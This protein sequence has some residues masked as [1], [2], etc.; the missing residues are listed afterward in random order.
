M[1]ERTLG[2]VMFRAVDR[3]QQESVVSLRFERPQ[4]EGVRERARRE[5]FACPGCEAVVLFKAGE[6]RRPHFAHKSRSECPLSSVGGLRLAL[7]AVLYEWLRERYGDCVEVE[8]AVPDVGLPGP[9]DCWVELEDGPRAWWIFDRQVRAPERR[10]ALREA[11]GRSGVRWTVVYPARMLRRDEQFRDAVHLTPTEREFVERSC[12]D[13][14]YERGRGSVG[15]L[16]Y[17]D[18]EDRRW[19]TL[20]AVRRSD[21]PRTTASLVESPL[22]ELRLQRSGEIVHPG[23]FD[24]LRRRRAR[25]LEAER[26][27]TAAEAARTAEVAEADAVQIDESERSEP[28]AAAVSRTPSWRA[29]VKA[30]EREDLE[31]RVEQ[32]RNARRLDPIDEHLRALRIRLEAERRESDRTRSPGTAAPATEGPSDPAPSPLRPQRPDVPCSRCGRLTPEIDQ[33]VFDGATGT[34]KCRDCL[35]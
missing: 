31:A 8:R 7:R 29:V 27:R 25:A 12:Y 17:L 15:S 21:G 34:C 32:R 18:E 11:F 13:P 26:A 22:A 1:G 4:W 30:V 5:E 33:L 2:P 28:P 19:T 9:A 10:V 23:E 3:V 16:H 20:R 24:A 14:L 6:K 35:A